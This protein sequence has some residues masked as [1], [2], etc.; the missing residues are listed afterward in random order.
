MFILSTT[1]FGCEAGR[2]AL[3]R[4]G[5]EILQHRTLSTT[6]VMNLGNGPTTAGIAAK[7]LPEDARVGAS[8]VL[9]RPVD[10]HRAQRGVAVSWYQSW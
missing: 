2:A 3:I 5:K 8:A 7:K 4:T 6:I 1:P 9:M 10:H